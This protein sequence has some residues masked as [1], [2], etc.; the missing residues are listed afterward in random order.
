MGS[1]KGKVLFCI[2]YWIKIVIGYDK[3]CVMDVGNFVEMGV[4]FELWEVEGVFRGMC[5][6]LGIGC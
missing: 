4:F 5:D 6:C 2:V 3:I 1:F